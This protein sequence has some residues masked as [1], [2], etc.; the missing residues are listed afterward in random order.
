MYGPWLPDTIKGIRVLMPY[1]NYW[2]IPRCPEISWTWD[3]I[4]DH[5]LSPHYTLSWGTCDLGH[6]DHTILQYWWNILSTLGLEIWDVTLCLYCIL[7]VWRAKLWVGHLKMFKISQVSGSLDF[8]KLHY[9]T[10]TFPGMLSLHTTIGRSILTCGACLTHFYTNKCRAFC[11]QKKHTHHFM[12][13][14]TA[15]VKLKKYIEK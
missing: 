7:D 9:M 11:T 14:T 8:G 3:S 5:T 13:N 4:W 10:G 6:C 15:K 1:F 12:S 2:N